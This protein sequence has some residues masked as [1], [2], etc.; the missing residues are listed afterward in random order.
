VWNGIVTAAQIAWNII[1]FIVQVVVY[2]IVALII[3]L[4]YILAGIWWLIST[5]ATWAWNTVILPVIQ[6][7]A[8]L[9]ILVWTGVAMFFGWLWGIIAAGAT[10]VWSIIVFIFALAAGFAMMIW[11]PVAA[12][13]GW[14]WGIISA[15]AQFAW[16]IIMFI[17]AI[18]AGS[19]MAVWSPV[20]GF[21]G[22]LFGMIR[23]AGESAWNG[24]SRAASAVA[25]V[26]RGAWNAVAGA[27]RSAY[28][29]IARGWNSIPS[30]TVPAWVP[31]LGG[32][33]FSLPKLP[34]LWRGG[35]IT[36]DAAIVGE[37]GPEPLVV[38]GRYAGML[39]AAG[40][41][42]ATGLPPGGYVTPSLETLAGMPGLLQGL[43][44]GVASAVSRSVPGYADLLAPAATVIPPP[45]SPGDDRSDS[46]LAA[47]VRSLSRTVAE[48]PPPISA[49][50]KD[51]EA[52]VLRALRRRERERELNA[53]YTY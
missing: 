5:A 6:F 39:G 21:F 31:G 45:A 44:S 13:F 42:I 41:E 46:E 20:A 30:I 17:F 18:A 32:N 40:P 3:G 51:T 12:F 33:T 8:A 37:R 22:W 9:A 43:P 34:M 53:R 1:S 28:N 4:S 24:I 52:A 48:R 10:Y 15:G 50:G 23:N 35:T 7:V 49:D 36:Y 2:V 14:L 27:V 19:A 29:A 25:G 26:V 38:N 16:N 47:A 11:Q